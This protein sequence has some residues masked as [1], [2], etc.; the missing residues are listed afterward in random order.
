M[1]KFYLIKVRPKVESGIEDRRNFQPHLL[2]HFAEMLCTGN[3]LKVITYF[4]H[5]Y[6][7]AVR[8]KHNQILIGITYDITGL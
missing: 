2:F 3:I 8:L 6:Q 7:I 4:I 1:T 5:S